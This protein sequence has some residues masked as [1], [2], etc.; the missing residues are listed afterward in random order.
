MDKIKFDQIL[1]QTTSLQYRKLRPARLALRPGEKRR[2][3][4]K[5]R[6]YLRFGTLYNGNTSPSTPPASIFAS[7]H[8]SKKNSEL[9]VVQHL[10]IVQ[11]DE[12]QQNKTIA[13]WIILAVYFIEWE[14]I[15]DNASDVKPLKIGLS[16]LFKTRLDTLYFQFQNA[17]SSAHEVRFWHQTFVAIRVKSEPLLNVFHLCP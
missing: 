3:T 15:N 6:Y 10:C 8:T 4:P 14:E 16:G 9:Q 13:D 2:W 5:V 7:F 1:L 11:D 17:Q 12:L